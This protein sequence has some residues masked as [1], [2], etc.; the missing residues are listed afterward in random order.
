MVYK[1]ITLVSVPN[2]KSF[3]PTKTELQAK[4]L[5]EFSIMLYGKNRAGGVLLPAIM[6]A[7]IKMYG[8]F[9]NFEQL[10]LLPL[11]MYRPETCRD[12]S[13]WGYLHSVK[14]LSK[15]SLIEI[16]DDV[17]ANHQLKM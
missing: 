3:G 10:Y 1:T 2:L 15:K 17:I 6:A 4:E 12:L 13:E 11:L 7:A 14:S 5:G 16:F 8:D 9:Q